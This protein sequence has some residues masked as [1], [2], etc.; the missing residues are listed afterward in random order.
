MFIIDLF[1][2]SERGRQRQYL[3]IFTQ[4]PRMVDGKD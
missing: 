1:E 3:R 4:D 2:Q